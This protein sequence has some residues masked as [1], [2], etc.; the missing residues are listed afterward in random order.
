[1]DSRIWKAQVSYRAHHYRVT[2]FDGRGNGRSDRPHGA[3]AYAD[4]QYV[5]DTVAVLDA[6]GIDSA[7]VVGV[8]MGGRWAVRLAAEHPERV[9]GLFTI[10]PSCGP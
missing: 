8:S 5:A 6:A 7:V 4:E 3:A 9:L 10:A 2:T 1:M